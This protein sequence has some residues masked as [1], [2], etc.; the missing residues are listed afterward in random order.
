MRFFQ[1]LT[2]ELLSITRSLPSTVHAIRLRA[3]V[4]GEHETECMA[5]AEEKDKLYKKLE[6]ELKG[7]EKMV[8]KSYAKFTIMVAEHLDIKVGAR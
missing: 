4:A 6:L 3:T 5:P 8:M 2:R 7:N 1:T